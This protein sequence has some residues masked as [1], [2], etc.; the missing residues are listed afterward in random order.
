M[1]LRGTRKLLTIGAGVSLVIAVT[2]ISVSAQYLRYRD[3]K[4]PRLP[5]G[6]PNM[7]AP[8]P[9][10][11]DGKPNLGG[12]WNAVDGRFLTNLSRRAGIEPPF[13]PWAAAL[14]KER[15]EN[16]GRDRPAGRCLPHTIPNAMLV[17]NYPWIPPDRLR[18]P[19]SRGHVQRSEGV[20]EAMV[21]NRAVHPAA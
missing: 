12:L 2:C 11:A 13:T 14:F 18:A 16:E 5:D 19:R 3:P 15:Q 6:T 9:R 17:P 10:L 4:A 7:T 1:M 20:Y 8:V 21:G